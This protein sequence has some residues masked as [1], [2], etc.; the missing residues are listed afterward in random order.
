MNIKRIKIIFHINRPHITYDILKVIRQHD[1]PVLSMEVYSNVIYLKLPEVS[2]DIIEDIRKGC[3]KVYGFHHLEEIDVM[4]FEEKDIELKSVL[5]LIREG[6]ILL[7][8]QGV[9]EYA[10][11]IAYNYIENL[12]RGNKI[13]NY[14]DR[15]YLTSYI[16]NKDNKST[17]KTIRNRNIVIG[18]KNY[19]LNLD[20]IYS[21]DENFCGYLLTLKEIINEDMSSLNLITFD[22]IIGKE[23]N[24]I[25][26]VEKAKLFAYSDAAVLLT[27]ESGTGKEMF[28][29]AIHSY[30]DRADKSFV[31]INCAA[32]PEELLE[33]ELFGYEKG[34]FTGANARGKRGIFELASGGT[35]FLDEIGEMNYHLQAKL[36]RGI[37][38]KKVRPLGSDREIELDIRI[39][40][41]TN[42]NL[43]ELI[44]ERKFRMDLF[45]RLNIFS[46]D[47]PPLR[48]RKEDIDLLISYFIKNLSK[49]YNR[50]KIRVTEEARKVLK[51]YSWPGNIRE[52]Q[53]VL[54]RAVVLSR[55]GI[56]GRED[57]SFDKH[58]GFNKLLYNNHDLNLAVGSFEKE[59]I[60][61]V[62]K[63]SRSIREAARKL[64]VTHTLLL[65][66]IKK[67]SI[68]ENMWKN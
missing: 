47:I 5:N 56:I 21:E 23:E 48:A 42:K 2:K 57:I 63:N 49:R 41:A 67:Y 30:S 39:I 9:V 64:N 60:L 8:R 19:L 35:V 26:V 16:N 1:L 11:K 51:S 45:Y 62:L 27:G 44:E 28:A 6:V 31:G 4:S 34:A 7:S 46:I 13:F 50:E 54:E 3:E 24:F 55:D 20:G 29:R 18:S 66:R 52:M 15:Q 61:K 59:F 68:T 37:Q 14:I 12:S 58:N 17:I 43:N 38:E 40:S 33:S 10:N 32:I 65:N 25:N 22:D 36:L 53:N